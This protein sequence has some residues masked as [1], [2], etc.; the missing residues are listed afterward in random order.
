MV[1]IKETLIDTALETNG[2][3]KTRIKKSILRILYKQK[4]PISVAD[5][6]SQMK[7][8]CDPST[9]FRAIHQFKDKGMIREVKLHEDFA[10]YE[11]WTAVVRS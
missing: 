8:Q 7:Q 10:R 11:V 5:I 1:N 6:H 9:I 4:N 3:K 2:F